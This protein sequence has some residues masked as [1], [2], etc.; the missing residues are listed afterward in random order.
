[1]HAWVCSGAL[2][3]PYGWQALWSQ[4]FEVLLLYVLLFNFQ[5]L[6]SQ[7]HDVQQKLDTLR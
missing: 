3:G 6:P 4:N 7:Q 1:M 5:S 2:G